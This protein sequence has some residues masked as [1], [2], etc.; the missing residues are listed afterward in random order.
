MTRSKVE[1]GSDAGIP[2]DD[3]LVRGTV[4]YNLKRAYMVLLPAAEAATIE[5]GL[6]VK[7][8]SCLSVIAQNP[9]IAPS[10]LAHRLRM[11]RSNIVVVID[12]L[13]TLDLI[14]REQNKSDRRRFSLTAT[15]RG[16]RVLEKAFSAVQRNESQLM[17]RFSSDE[18]A[19]LIELLNKLE[20]SI[21]G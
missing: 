6:K 21:P 2:E 12:E 7:T 9:G 15:L 10:E 4:G 20:A 13:E 1:D 3:G 17:H 16:R 14:K 18:K 5:Q 8:F 19:K 11:E